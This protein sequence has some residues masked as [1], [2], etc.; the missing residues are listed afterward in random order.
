MSAYLYIGCFY[1]CFQTGCIPHTNIREVFEGIHR[2]VLTADYA[3]RVA[4]HACLQM[5]FL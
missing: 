4:S 2:W 5:A 1:R 3:F